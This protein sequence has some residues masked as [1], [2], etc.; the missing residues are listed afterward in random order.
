MIDNVAIVSSRLRDR[1]RSQGVGA[2]Q[3]KGNSAL[4][5]QG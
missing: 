3:S 4:E 1:L 5:S 2:Y